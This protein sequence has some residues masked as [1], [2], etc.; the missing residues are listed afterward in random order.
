VINFNGKSIDPGIL[1]QVSKI[2]DDPA[3]K[4]TPELME[5]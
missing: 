4:F 3:Y 5:K 2:I 1:T